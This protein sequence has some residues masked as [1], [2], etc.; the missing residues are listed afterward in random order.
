[1]ITRSRHHAENAATPTGAMFAS[2][3]SA[4][5]TAV[6]ETREPDWLCYLSPTGKQPKG[7]S[8]GRH[9]RMQ[10]TSLKVHRMQSAQTSGPAEMV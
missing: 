2:V 8:D 4:T 10:H 6:S 9:G 7:G 1:M 3:E 5:H